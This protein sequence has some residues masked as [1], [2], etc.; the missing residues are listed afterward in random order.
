MEPLYA[1]HEGQ[2]VVGQAGLIP[3]NLKIKDRTELAVW[4]IDFQ[5]VPEMQ[6]K[7]IGQ[8]LTAA[9]MKSCPMFADIAVSFERSDNTQEM[10]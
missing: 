10:N 6:R 4:H 1:I 9:W 7:G 3:V 5:L 8:A 2:L